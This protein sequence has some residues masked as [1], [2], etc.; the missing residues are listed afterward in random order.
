MHNHTDAPGFFPGHG[1][2]NTLLSRQTL[3]TDE[4]QITD[5][6]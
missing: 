3:I 4:M 2:N 6:E 1:K 5:M